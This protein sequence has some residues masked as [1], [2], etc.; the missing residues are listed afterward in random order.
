MFSKPT[1][2]QVLA[3]AAIFQACHLV[4][5][6]AN[7]G[8]ASSRDTE[9]CMKALLNQSPGS[10][11][12]L[13]GGRQNLETGI[14]AIRALLGEQNRGNIN[15]A[16]SMFSS[17]TVTYVISVLSIERLLQKQPAMLEA[18]GSGIENAVRQAEHFSVVHDNVVA[19]LASLYQETISRLRQRIQI[20]GNG[21]FLQ[22]PKVAERIRCLLFSAIRSAVLWRQLGGKKHHLLFYR[23]AILKTLKD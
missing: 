5:C 15:S 14:E 4:D 19:N 6:L 10:L 9:Q 23:Q 16:S 12:D 3:L 22:Q 20:K 2:D 1:D 18:V 17:T 13:Y 21:V 7:S 8:E 11:E